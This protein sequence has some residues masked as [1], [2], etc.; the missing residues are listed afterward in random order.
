MHTAKLVVLLWILAV[1]ML[2]GVSLQESSVAGHAEIAKIVLVCC[3]RRPGATL[4]YFSRVGWRGGST[5]ECGGQGCAISK[6][7]EVFRAALVP[8]I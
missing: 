3:G 7:G 5:E 4:E 1:G 2:E 6:L 8:C